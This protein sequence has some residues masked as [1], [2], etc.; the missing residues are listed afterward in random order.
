MALRN[1]NQSIFH[2]T[3][4]I[5]NLK[6]ILKSESFKIQYCTEKIYVSKNTSVHIAVPMVSFADIRL[7]D[8]VRSFKQPKIA[9][10]TRSLGYYGDYAIG[11]TKAWAIKKN[12]L[13]ILYIPKPTKS[14][15]LPGN[16]FLKS[17]TPH[18][19][20]SIN[21]ADRGKNI[22]GLPPV[23]SFCKHYVGVLE[24]NPGLREEYGFHNEQEWRYVPSDMPIKWNF[25]NN[26]LEP[27][28]I[29]Q[30]KKKAQLN[31]RISR[32]LK[33]DIWQ[34]VTFVV[35][36]SQTYVKQIIAIFDAVRQ[37]KL[38]RV[39]T[40]GEQ[41]EIQERFQYLCS[42]IITTEQLCSDL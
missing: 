14:T 41:Q 30:Q 24:N 26:K 17:L 42:C 20:R 3:S 37:A 21:L 40:A 9:G 12:V 13:P 27:D 6:Q 2:H 4:S 18:A 19:V 35:V 8:Y 7:T 28:Y 39:A 16:H 15:T 23:A 31:K 11:V 34:D 36:R 1:E 32:E 25:F 10:E 29:N 38:L 22:T 5:T 33:F